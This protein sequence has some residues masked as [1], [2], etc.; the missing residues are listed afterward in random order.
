M[1]LV[2]VGSVFI[3]TTLLVCV[4]SFYVIHPKLLITTDISRGNLSSGFLYETGSFQ[5]NNNN[6]ND[7][8]NDNNNNNNNDKGYRDNNCNWYDRNDP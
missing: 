2:I 3:E 5:I 7:Y 8:N 1:L 6:N 4:F